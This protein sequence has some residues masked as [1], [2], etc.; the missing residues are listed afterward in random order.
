MSEVA[1][2]P[3]S[4]PL[5]MS[6]FNS[7]KNGDD[8]CEL[9]SVLQGYDLFGHFDGSSVAPPKFAI[10]GEDGATSELTAAYKDWIRTDKALLSLLIASL[11][12]EALEYVIGSQ[13]SREAWLH[14]YDRYASVS[15]ARINHLKT[16]LQTAQKGGDSIERF[17]LRLKHIRD[18]LRAADVLIS[19]DDFVIAALNGLP[20]E[21]AIIKTVLIARDSPI[22]LKDFCAQLLAAEQ[23][24]EARIVHHSGLYAANSS[25]SVQPSFVASGQGLLP[26]PS[27]PLPPVHSSRGFSSCRGRS[28]GGRNQQSQFRSSSFHGASSSNYGGY[29]SYK[30]VPKCQICSKRGHT[31]ENYYYRNAPSSDAPSHVVE[32]QICGKRGHIALDCY[33]RSNYAFQG[34]APPSS[35]TAMTA[36]S[37]Y[38]PEQVWIDDT[39]ASHHMVGNASHL[40]NVTSCDVTE[41][42]TVGNGEGLEII[43]LGTTSISCANTRSLSMP[44][45][46]H[47]KLTKQIVLQGKSNQGLYHIPLAASSVLNRASC[48]SSAPVAYLGQQIKSSLW[49][50]RLGHPTNEVVKLMLQASAVSVSALCSACLHGKMHKLPFPSE[51]IKSNIA[52]QRIHSDVWGPSRNK[53]IDGYRYYVSFVDECTGFL[54]LYPLFN[55]SGVFEI[56]LKFYAFISTQFGARLQY[57]QSDGGGEFNSSQFAS[58]LD[59]KGIIHQ[60]SCPSTPQQNG[61][62][63]RKNR[64]VIETALTLSVSANLPGQFWYH[65]VAHAAYLI[66]F[67]PSIA[68]G[69]QSPFQKLFEK[70]PPLQHI[71]VFGT[72][73][74]KGVICYN[75]TTHRFL[76]SRHVIHDESVFP[77]RHS[78]PS[79]PFSNLSSCT[80]SSF[81]APPIVVSVSY[82]VP[83]LAS[84]SDPSLASSH[85]SDVPFHVSASFGDDP[86]L[87]ALGADSIDNLQ[88]LSAQQLQVLLPSHESSSPSMPPP[89]HPMQT[90]SK[91]GIVKTKPFEDYQCYLTT[92]PPFH[93]AAE[94]TTYMA[95]SQSS[96]WIQA[97]REEI[98]ALH[99]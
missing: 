22:T 58:F 63:E 1:A 56:F 83:S 23:T 60:L 50:Q 76:L 27:H 21:Y 15:R 52:F 25:F 66:N 48:F 53:S 55:K 88:V 16:E 44:S 81:K 11:L 85:S 2:M 82:H 43:N 17:L 19:D 30:V 35:L 46:F 80:P 31:V 40:H 39:G 77:F 10:V 26:T 9:K 47:D 92:I 86:V 99:T 98:E 13:T 4:L 28:N 67:M 42:V 12:D 29:G 36:Q 61:L 69:N 24:T 57:F 97:M 70:P 96:V 68:L 94:P 93:E 73:G 54:W 89:M 14:L 51:H 7:S 62:D 8:R 37:S 79:P 18:Q 49:H 5:M 34:Q 91:S 95:A 90:R 6:S 75:T 72:V 59:S 38:S 65:A 20:P 41:N 87:V 64:H 74:Y 71:R 3:Q 84:C 45:V 78:E 33:H 32:C